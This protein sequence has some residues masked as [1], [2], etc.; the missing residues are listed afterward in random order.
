MTHTLCARDVMSAPVHVVSINDTMKDAWSVLQTFGVRHLV[1]C[2]GY[3]CAGVLDDRALFAHWPTGPF[4][5][6]STPVRE[7]VAARTTCVLPETTLTR[8]A[9]VMTRSSSISRR[10]GASCA[11]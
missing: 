8:V 7:L 6:S 3:R 11:H 4:G 10:G 2:D 1:V 5:V 9:R